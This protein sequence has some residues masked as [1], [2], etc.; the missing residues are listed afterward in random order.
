MSERFEYKSALAS[1]MNGFVELK[2]ASGTNNLRTKWILLEID[3]FYM[4][5][6]I[7]VPTIT[8]EIITEWRKTRTND[9]QRTLYTKYSVW[10]QLARFMCRQGNECYIPQLPSHRGLRDCFTLSLEYMSLA[11]QFAE[12]G[13]IYGIR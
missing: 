11:T 6:N 12:M 8:S 2:E 7:T 4:G 1:Y 5:N 9:C 3:K 13:I 10:S